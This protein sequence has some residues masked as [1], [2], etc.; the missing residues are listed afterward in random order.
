[1]PSP[2]NAQTIRQLARQIRRLERTTQPATQADRV[3]ST[4]I[5]PL[6]GLLPDQGF[7]PGTLVEWLSARPGSGAGTLAFTAAAR[8]LRNDRALVV[9]DPD[10]SFHPPALPHLLE[11]FRPSL[12]E[13]TSLLERMVIVH[14]ETERDALW[15]L[16][17]SLRCPAVAVTV[18]W[19]D[20]LRS[21]VCRRL[22]LAVETGGGIGMLLRSGECRV[23]PSWADI[24]LLVEP[25]ASVSSSSSAF[26]SAADSLSADSTWNSR[27]LRLEL[28]HCRG[29]LSGGAVELEIDDATGDV[30]L[31]SRMAPAA[32]S[33]R[34]A[35]A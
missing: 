19:L 31:A 17:Q 6:D 29:R 8:L 18:C 5:P 15:A 21:Q 14:P 24:R 4:G 26:L 22:Q 34:A 23:D 28:L 11:P 20:Q 12:S 10:R 13:Q 33:Y 30:R 35:G 9:V 25:L 1:M 7:P 32:D 3:L 16:E 27:Q 2:D